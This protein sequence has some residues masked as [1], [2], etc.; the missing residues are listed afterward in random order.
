VPVRFLNYKIVIGVLLFLFVCIGGYIGYLSALVDVD[1]QEYMRQVDDATD[2]T[3]LEKQLARAKSILDARSRAYIRRSQ[4][5]IRQKQ[6]ELETSE[7]PVAPESQLERVLEL[8]ET[9]STIVPEQLNTDERVMLKSLQEEQGDLVFFQDEVNVIEQILAR[10][11]DDETIASAGDRQ[12]RRISDALR[13]LFLLLDKRKELAQQ[14]QTALNG[15]EYW[16]QNPK[17]KPRDIII[18]VHNKDGVTRVLNPLHVTQI[19]TA[20]SVMPQGFDRRLKN[21]YIVYG[22]SKMR[23]GMSGVGV[24]FMKGEELDFFRVL[25]HELGHIYDLHREVSAGEKSQF[26]D[27]PYR[28]FVGDPS[29]TYYEYSWL[30][31]SQRSADKTAFAST[32]G[33]SDPF[34]DFAEAFALY[35]LQNETFDDWKDSDPIFQN[36]FVYMNGIFNGRTFKSSKKFLAQPYDVTMLEVNYDYLLDLEG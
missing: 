13:E 9:L 5:F 8:N 2:K 4:D 36:K 17:E 15:Y 32:Y 26:Y 3:R 21:L 10:E 30:S 1:E 27:G 16:E 14:R 20:L 11:I 18:T 29:V 33:M 35:I 24:V 25:V 6:L 19:T 7:I 34:E 12:R 22:D 31:N 28:L 23:R